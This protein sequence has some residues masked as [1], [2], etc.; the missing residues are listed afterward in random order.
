MTPYFSPFWIIL[1][2]IAVV[3]CVGAFITDRR[4]YARRLEQQALDDQKESLAASARFR[5]AVEDRKA[6]NAEIEARQTREKWAI[7]DANVDHTS[8]LPT[9]RGGEDGLAGDLVPWTKP[10]KVKVTL[11]VKKTTPKKSVKSKAK[12]GKS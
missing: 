7:V 4:R 9:S 10:K 3:V 11:K 8:D 5:Q 12:K 2:I 1:L 6:K